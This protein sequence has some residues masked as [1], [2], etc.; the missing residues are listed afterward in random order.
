MRL[1]FKITSQQLE[2]IR[3]DLARS[4]A[5][6]FERVGFICCR[7]GALSPSGLIILA[8]DYR[9]VADEHYVDAPGYGA[10][11]GEAAIR[12]A[13]QHAHRHAVG[14]FHVHAHGG[15]G[16]PQFSSTD[17]REMPNFV[18]DF[19]NVRGDVPHGALVLSN[20]SMFGYCWLPGQRTKCI[21]KEFVVVGA[22]LW[23]SGPAHE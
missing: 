13:M 12:D 18:P 17:E 11:M 14:M 2:Q 8:A 16:R 10:L 4:H 21:L 22:S 20:D 5:F 19:F 1:L 23:K 3:R 15:R 9:P 6:A 7:F